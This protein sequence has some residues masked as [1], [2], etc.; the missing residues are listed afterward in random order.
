MQRI[1]VLG[2]TGFIG[3]HFCGKASQ[4]GC[5]L[6]VVTRRS[7]S[8]KAV[9]TLPWVDVIVGD[10]HDEATLVRLLE[11]HDAV[12]NL[13]AILHGT[14]A[15][16]HHV[17]VALVEKLVRACVARGVR[18]VL[19][20]SALG[21]ALDA[22]SMYQ[23]SKAQGEAALQASGLDVALLRPSVVFGA[24]DQFLNLFAKLQAV[25]PLMPLAGASARFQPVWVED[26]AQA[27]VELLQ[28]LSRGTLATGPGRVVEACG[29]DVFT[30]AELVRL[31]GRYAGHAR[32]ILPLPDALARLQA[33]VM[34]WA[35]GKTLMSRDNLDSMRVDNV[36]TGK[37]PGLQALGISASALDT[38]A[39]SYLQAVNPDPMLKRRRSAGRF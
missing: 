15:A 35:P 18:R 27:M 24:G 22:P 23:R 38:I 28:R 36:A 5:R 30:L 8:A 25:F 17:H 1:L 34:E 33:L 26:V 21:A 29:P 3:R 37:V 7:E 6:T 9:Q 16:F 10:A 11:G 31:A 19:H 13:V 12:V 2:G 20:V 14:Q 4:P 32:P 39:P